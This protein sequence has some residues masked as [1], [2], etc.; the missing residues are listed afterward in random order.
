[1][2]SDVMTNE[3]I[4]L[5]LNNSGYPAQPHPIII[6]CCCV[7]LADNIFLFDRLFHLTS[8]G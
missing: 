2:F 1:M 6:N 8:G 7:T 5:G 4:D 3:K